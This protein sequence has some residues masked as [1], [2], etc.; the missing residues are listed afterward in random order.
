MGLH[1][2]LPR[3]APMEPRVVWVVTE[4]LAEPGDVQ[5]E[6]WEQAGWEGLVADVAVR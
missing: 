1:C 6:R 5:V 3:S 2:L 4:A